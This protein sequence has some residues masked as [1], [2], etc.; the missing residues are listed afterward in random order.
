MYLLP[1]YFLYAV[2]HPFNHSRT[3]YGVVSFVFVAISLDHCGHARSSWRASVR[4]SED[5]VHTARLS[6]KSICHLFLQYKTSLSNARELPPQSSLV[7]HVVSTSDNTCE[8]VDLYLK[9]NISYQ[10]YRKTVE[11]IITQTASNLVPQ[12]IAG[13]DVSTTLIF[14]YLYQLACTSK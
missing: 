6:H 10:I 2:N 3:K 8:V 12:A 14:P 7:P 11:I 13:A 5:K 1:M 4:R 9:S